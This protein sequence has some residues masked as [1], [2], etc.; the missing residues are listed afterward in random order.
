MKSK[1]KKKKS[2]AKKHQETQRQEQ[3]VLAA[4]AVVVEKENVTTKLCQKG[5]QTST[6]KLVNSR[7]FYKEHGN[8]IKLLENCKYYVKNV[9]IKQR[10]Y[11]NLQQPQ[12]LNVKLVNIRH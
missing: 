10:K 9:N 7:Q 2:A 1:N 12:Y 6:N 8:S 3:Q 4:A 5:K 11:H